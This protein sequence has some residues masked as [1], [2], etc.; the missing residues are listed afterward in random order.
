[1]LEYCKNRVFITGVRA[2]T[3]VLVQ[4]RT[5]AHQ[6]GKQYFPITPTFQFEVLDKEHL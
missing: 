2:S 6:H 5:P 3:P 4:A 1:M